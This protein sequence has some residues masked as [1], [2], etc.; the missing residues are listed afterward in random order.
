MDL[1]DYYRL[2]L[3]NFVVVLVSTILGIVAAAGITYNQTPI[4]QGNVQLFVSTPSS[5]LD[6]SALAQ[7]SSFSQQR[8]ISYA[9]IINGPE[10]LNPVIAALKLPYTEKQL[11]EQVKATAPLNTVLINVTVSNPNAQLAADIANAIGNQFSLTA[12]NL[13]SPGSSSTVKVTMVKSAIPASSPSSPKKSLNLL[14]GLILGFGIGIGLSILRQIF[15]N[16]VKNDLDLGDIPLLAAIGLDAEAIE[17][18]LVTEIGRY[19]ARTEAFRSLRTNIQFIKTE[20]P[21]QII[22]VSSSLPGEG[23]TTTA[24]NLSISMAQSGLRVLFLEGDLRRPR[25]GKYLRI[26]KKKVG[27]T[28]VLTGRVTDF[29]AK[30]L[31]KLLLDWGNDGMKYLPSGNVP[32]NPSE[33]LNSGNLDPFFTAVRKHFDFVIIDSPPLLPVTD[34]AILAKKSDGVILIAKAGSIRIGQLHG[35]EE[36]LRAVGANVLGAVLNMIPENA[37]D[38][39]N[40]GYRY[41]YTYGYRSKR[42]GRYGGKY[43]GKY[44]GEYGEYGA[45]DKAKVEVELGP[46]SPLAEDVEEARQQ[47]QSRDHKKGK[48]NSSRKVKADHDSIEEPPKTKYSRSR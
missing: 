9:Q 23:K 15:D 39:D 38:S 4:Y 28:D 26:G 33:L 46:Y 44:S 2:I 5:M 11:S 19:S 48:V 7:G 37:R 29:S 45:I 36:A 10:T 32:P 42:G 34:G 27:F 22:T 20:S 43:G 31:N 8:V 47:E 25:S 1:K 18:P 14:L 30:G 17:K 12:S 16:T 24:L 21:I 40:Y 41:G 3:Q 6:I 35:S 13:E